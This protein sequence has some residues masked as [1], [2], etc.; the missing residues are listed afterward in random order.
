M[1]QIVRQ[2]F[3]KYIMQSHS[4]RKKKQKKS[5]GLG[6][7][8]QDAQVFVL[9]LIIFFRIFISA[10]KLFQQCW[11]VGEKEMEFPGIFSSG[12]VRRGW[13]GVGG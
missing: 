11:Q 9:I 5:R 1:R 2:K 12:I 3:A 8:C 10:A 7:S 4:N 13:G 6:L